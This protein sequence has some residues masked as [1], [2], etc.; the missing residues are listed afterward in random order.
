MLAHCKAA[1][2]RLLTTNLSR[3][4]R[5]SFILGDWDILG[6]FHNFVTKHH[7]IANIQPGEGISNRCGRYLHVLSRTWLLHNH[8]WKLMAIHG[9]TFLPKIDHW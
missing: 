8:T 6:S 9:Y 5:C 1:S 2:T 4:S 3:V 7:T